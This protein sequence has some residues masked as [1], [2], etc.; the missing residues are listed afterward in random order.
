MGTVA[1]FSGN[2][3]HS[4]TVGQPAGVQP[5]GM[6]MLHGSP[7]ALRHTAR[8]PCPGRTCC[9]EAGAGQRHPLLLPSRQ[10]DSLLPDL[11]LVACRAE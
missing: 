3:C 6:P 7:A 11:R 1:R 5:H 4:K 8:Q 2:G 9:R 10:V